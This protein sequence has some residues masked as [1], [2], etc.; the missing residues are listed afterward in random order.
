MMSRTPAHDSHSIVAAADAIAQTKP[1]WLLAVCVFALALVLGLPTGLAQDPDDP[2]MDP[3]A[4]DPEQLEDPIDP[5]TWQGLPPGTLPEN[6]LREAVVDGCVNR[7]VE[8][9]SFELGLQGVAVVPLPSKPWL[10]PKVEIV[11]GGTHGEKAMSVSGGAVLRSRWFQVDPDKAKSEEAMPVV[12]SLDARASAS[13][14]VEL[15]ILG[16]NTKKPLVAETLDVSSGWQRLTA[17]AELPSPAAT[18][19]SVRIELVMTDPSVTFTVD[20]IQIEAGDTAT[21][22]VYPERVATKLR[23]L[24]GDE[25]GLV[26]GGSSVKLEALFFNPT[27]ADVEYK[28]VVECFDIDGKLVDDEKIKAEVEAN[29]VVAED[30]SFK[31]NG[32]GGYRVVMTVTPDGEKEPIARRSA[33]FTVVDKFSPPSSK[34]EGPDARL[35]VD[36]SPT[37]LSIDRAKLLGPRWIRIPVNTGFGTW[38]QETAKGKYEFRD[39]IA[40]A[41]SRS[42]TN[43]IGVIDLVR[44]GFPAIP[45]HIKAKDAADPLRN[46]LGDRNQYGGAAASSSDGEA[47]MFGVPLLS[48]PIGPTK[49]PKILEDDKAPKQRIPD[50]DA[51]LKAWEDFVYALVNHYGDD[52]HAWQIGSKPDRYYTPDEY[53]PLLQRA[54]RAVK[55]ANKDAKVILNPGLYFHTDDATV[56]LDKLIDAGVHEFCDVLQM[57]LEPPRGNA[58]ASNVETLMQEFRSRMAETALAEKPMWLEF[59]LQ[60]LP[61]DDS[62]LNVEAYRPN[63]W[64]WAVP[65]REGGRDPKSW[66]WGDTARWTTRALMVASR[67]GFEN[68]VLSGDTYNPRATPDRPVWQDTMSEYDGLPSPAFATVQAQ[69]DL[70][71]GYPVCS[72][73]PTPV[74]LPSD[75]NAVAFTNKEKGKHVVAMWLVLNRKDPVEYTASQNPPPG[76][77]ELMTANGESIKVSRDGLK[78]IVTESPIY[79]VIEKCTLEDFG[80]WLRQGKFTGERFDPVSRVNRALRNGGGANGW[81]GRRPPRGGWGG[82]GPGGG[83]R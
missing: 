81:G 6:V 40:A 75:V 9:S 71:R 11:D 47:R 10:Q 33:S 41:Y 17:T 36:A 68:V 60:M 24:S 25:R 35:V 5:E 55:R 76:S 32:R 23:V 16:L 61:S 49:P 58:E 56:F 20:S 77:V 42:G 8:G 37:T 52:I 13:T 29:S 48:N 15:R 12:V 45:E 65:Y 51:A 73:V 43:L 4:E 62:L 54:Y 67:E 31:V 66:Q 69:M 50:G 57:H 80:I 1:F 27:N 78:M 14:P 74:G 28:A 44:D 64:I 59:G 83:R 70:T 26:T 19:A 18:F 22:F 30:F 34:A 72:N 2:G 7:F 39:A 21:K 38:D 3:D 53:L 79:F 46:P 82:R 63:G